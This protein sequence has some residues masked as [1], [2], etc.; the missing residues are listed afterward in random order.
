MH[1]ILSSFGQSVSRDIL[2]KTASDVDVVF[3]FGC[4]RSGTFMTAGIFG[5]DD[6][7]RV[8]NERSIISFRGEKRLRLNPLPGVRRHLARNRPKLSV[9]RPLVE[10]Q[11]ALELLEYFPVARAFWIYR[12]HQD[13]LASNLAK[14]GASNANRDLGP[15]MRGDLRNWRAEGVDPETARLV[16]DLHRRYP[17]P[18]SAA[19]LFW[20]L[21]NALF[22]SQALDRHAR[23]LLIKYEDLVAD[24]GQVVRRMYGFIGWPF[25]GEHV[26][27]HVNGRSVGRGQGSVPRREVDAL[28]KA[29]GSRLESIYRAQVLR[30]DM[31]AASLAVT[32]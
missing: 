19:A 17:D 30:L 8:Y 14:F 2:R 26:I 31:E 6:R 7:A 4:Q 29:L 1:A 32:G 18:M 12:N 21:R 24:P 23:V 22:F 16:R 15:L 28:C 20:Y 3:L 11:R 9:L 13:V 27:A 10:S 25:P 5:G